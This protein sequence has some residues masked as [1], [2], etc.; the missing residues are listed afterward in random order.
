MTEKRISPQAR[1]RLIVTLDGE[2]LPQIADLIETLKSEVK[3][4]KIGLPLFTAFGPKV[5]DL[6]LKHDCHP[7]FDLKY[8]DIPSSVSRAVATATT[9]GARMINVHAAG[10][11]YMMSE[12]IQAAREA[13]KRAGKPNPLMIGVTVLTSLQSLSD[14]GLQFELREQ[15]LRL[16]RMAKDAG[17]DG[18]LASPLEIRQIRQAC[19]PDFL[20]VTPGIRLS[21]E[22]QDDQR[23][24]SSPREAVNAGA[25]YIVVG[26][27]IS[28]AKDPLSIARQILKEMS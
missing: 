19:G 12:S 27:P 11:Q 13:A 8:H 14:I 22:L 20:I 6:V 3:N 17:M 7:F 26:R 4:F 16:A 15:V 24:I 2:S 23:R 5:V 21:H 18:V 1:K 9:M 10:G 28:A 25:D